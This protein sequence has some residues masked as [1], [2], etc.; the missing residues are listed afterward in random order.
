M[1]LQVSVHGHGRLMDPPSRN[2]MWRFG[3][4]NPVNYNDNEVYCG[5]YGSED[6]VI[7]TSVPNQFSNP[8]S[9]IPVQFD[10]YDGKCGV[11]GDEFGQEPPRDHESGGKFGNGIIGKRY[12]MGQ[13]RH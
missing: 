12:V 4:T 9:L 6:E 13:V 10:K 5:G 8:Y 3:F 7:S 11:C 2:A 1:N